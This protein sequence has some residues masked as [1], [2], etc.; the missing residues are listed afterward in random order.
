MATIKTSKKTTPTTINVFYGLNEST[1]GDTELKLGE[2]SVMKNWRVTDGGKL[3][4][5]E[6]YAPLF[7]SLGTGKIQGQWYGKVTGT[8]YH[9]FAYGG[10]IYKRT[11][12]TN[13]IIGTM[14]DAPTSFFFFNEKVYMKNGHEY[15][16][17]DGTTFADV[18]GYRPKIAISTPPGGGG[19]LYEETNRLTGAK[20]QTFSPSGTLTAYQLAETAITSVDF[21]YDG[22]T[23]KTAG[24][25]YTVNLTT[26]IVTFTTAP[27][28][29]TPNSI[30]IGW[31]KGTGDRASILGCLFAR[32]YGGANDSRVFIFGNDTTRNRLYYT[33]LADTVPSAE[34]FP[35]NGYI[36]VGS[37]EFSVTDAQKHQSSLL[38][39]TEKG[40]YYASYESVTLSSGLVAASFPAYSINDIKGNV[41][42]GQVKIINN[43]PLSIY[44]GIYEW[45][46]ITV[47]SDARNANYISRRVQPSLDLVDL[48]KA[49]TFDWEEKGEYWL[50]VGSL[51]WIY[52]YRIGVW[53]QREN[54]KAYNFLEIDGELYFGTD[55]TIMKFDP[56]LRTDNG[57]A[58]KAVWEMNFYDFG[59]EYLNKYMNNVWAS[60]KPDPKVRLDIATVT[61]N[62][63]TGE[64]QTIYYSLATFEHADFNK[65]S[66]LTSYNPQPF[67][68]EIQA[69]GFTYFKLILTNESL[70][71][72]CTVLSINMP[73]RM[74]GKVR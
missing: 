6:G 17:W 44:E 19:T 26:G 13:T 74:G 22:T 60:I 55:G 64:T 65:W 15:K 43:N 35:A 21:V 32:V 68:I 7:T 40:S 49:V 69:M 38:I 12:G 28:A 56:D 51:C 42:L 58:I 33:G 3:K 72:D 73:A 29:G 2:A 47:G 62:D 37:D 63:G 45:T 54:V 59:F 71:E 9:L 5:M 53:Y 39:F 20:H 61:N 52:N 41:A 57:I 16:S 50:C 25:D 66:F 48:T 4:K 1:D 70:N 34:Y 10:S 11:S 36:E 8:F 67:Y 18:A 27:T 23:L 30:D 46:L 24:T 14:T 31:T